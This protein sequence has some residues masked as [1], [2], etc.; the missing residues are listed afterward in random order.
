MKKII[1]SLVAIAALSSA[2]FAEVKLSFYNKLY[3]DD[4]IA[5]HSDAADETTTDFPAL[6]ERMFVEVL[7]DKVDAM[8]KATFALDDFDEKHF[9]LQGSVNDWYIEF[10]P[11]E[12]LTLGLHT[13]IFAD[14]SYLPVFDDNIGAGNIGSDGFTVTVRPVKGLRISATADFTFDGDPA[15][16]NWLNGKKDAG[17]DEEFN[18]GIGAIYAHDLF[19]VGLSIQDAID[20]DDRQIGFYAAFPKLFGKVEPLTLRLG[21]AYADNGKAVDDLI[22][23]SFAGTLTSVNNVCAGGVDYE[24]LFNFSAVYEAEKFT[25][26][27]EMLYNLD[28]AASDYDLYSAASLSLGMVEKLTI[29][30]TGKILAD[31]S[32]SG[33]ENLLGAGLAFDYDVNDNHTVGAAF[34]MDQCDKDYAIAVPVY[35]KYHF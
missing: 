17:E 11:F 9:G 29:T 22:G 1:A 35:W 23:H 3:E 19:E 4:A 20:S 31:L 28:D 27:A 32:S 5:Y 8:V 34:E 7:S 12:V 18:I 10:R 14:G 24:K 13:G 21:F 30:A 2:A 25:V 16:V 6:K 15:G 33:A 26:A